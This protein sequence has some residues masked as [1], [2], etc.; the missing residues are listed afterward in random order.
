MQNLES[1]FVLPVVFVPPSRYTLGILNSDLIDVVAL[2]G[3]PS[4]VLGGRRVSNAFA[5]ANAL[6]EGRREGDA[7]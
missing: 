2:G 4:R 5:G 1:L 6:G 7:S 3:F